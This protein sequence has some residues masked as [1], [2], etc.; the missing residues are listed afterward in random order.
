LAAHQELCR[1]VFCE[2]SG[3]E[4][5]TEGDAFFVAFSSATDATLAAVECQRVLARNPWSPDAEIRIRIG[6][7][8]G[9]ARVVGSEYVGLAVHRAARICSAAHG[10][11]V[12]ISGAT[13]ELLESDRLPDVGLRELGEH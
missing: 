10:G 12:L 2:H 5:G 13:A 8:T 9:E 7:H 6:V 4:F 11:Q 3:Y 1:E